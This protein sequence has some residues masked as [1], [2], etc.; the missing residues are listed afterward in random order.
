[1]THSPARLL[2]DG[3]FEI[4]P[5]DTQ[6]QARALRAGSPADIARLL[7]DAEMALSALRGEF[8]RWMETE[9]ERLGVL[10]AVV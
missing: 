6:L 4:T 7:S 8:D 2:A 10:A 3:E 5:A 1:M 9:V